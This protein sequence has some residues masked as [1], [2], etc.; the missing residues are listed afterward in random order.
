MSHEQHQSNV[1]S[2][3]KPIFKSRG[4]TFP[5]LIRYAQDNL[6]R[7]SHIRRPGQ[8]RGIRLF[9]LGDI[10]RLISENI[11]T[12]KITTTAKEQQ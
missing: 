8:T 2:R 4:I 5:Q 11:E 1:W 12:P 9:H 7:T 10:D 6:V 3:A